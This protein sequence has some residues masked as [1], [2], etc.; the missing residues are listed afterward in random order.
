MSGTLGQEGPDISGGSPSQALVSF[1]LL[2]PFSTLQLRGP[3]LISRAFNDHLQLTEGKSLQPISVG[4]F[5]GLSPTCS[6][7]IRLN[8]LVVF[9]FF[10]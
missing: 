7:A 5:P 6:R 9:S 8:Y 1:T 10:L 4:A 3:E 2:N